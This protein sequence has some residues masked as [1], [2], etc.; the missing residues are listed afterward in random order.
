MLIELAS[1]FGPIVG[2]ILVH[3]V[4]NVES[5]VTQQATVGVTDRLRRGLRGQR[6]HDLERALCAAVQRAATTLAG[7]AAWT[8]VDRT[9][10][11]HL[12]GD[13][14]DLF[15]AGQPGF[16][17]AVL[18]AILF[19]PEAMLQAQLWGAIHPWLANRTPVF[20]DRDTLQRDLPP[21]LVA[22]FGE[23]LKDRQHERAWIAFERELLR[24]THRLLRQQ[25]ATVPESQR[26][27][28]GALLTRLDALAEDTALLGQIVPV[29][30]DAL[31]GI[32]R[33]EAD[34]RDL[35]ALLGEA[36]ARQEER[37]ERLERALNRRLLT[38]VYAG[39]AVAARVEEII[40]EYTEFF[41]S[42]D[43]DLT[44][45]DA[46]VADND[47]GTLAVTGP[48]GFGKS[49]LLANWIARRRGNGLDTACHVFSRR[50]DETRPVTSG[51]RNLLRQLCVYHELR[52]ESIPTDEAGL[53]DAIVGLL[54]ERGAR[55]DEPLVI[56]VD[57]LDEAEAPFTPPLPAALPAGVFV[58]VSVRAGDDEEP[59]HLRGWP[60]NRQRLRLDRLPAAA[61]AV[62]LRR[63]GAGELAALADDPAFV[64]RIGERTDGFALYLR[65]LIGDL[66]ETVRAGGDLIAAVNR[67]PPRLSAY[68]SDRLTELA[69]TN[70]L[71]PPV[72]ELFAL[73]AVADGPLPAEDVR[74]LTG[75]T[76]FGLLG[77][78]WQVTRWFTIAEG[79]RS[80]AFAHPLLGDEFE[81]ALGAQA[82][83]ALDKL[84]GYC[85]DW[86]RHRSRYAFRHLPGHLREADRFE[87]LFA[88]ARDEAFLQA[89]VAAFPS[90]PAL[91]IE[92]LRSALDCAVQLGEPTASAAAE[93]L[94][95]HMRHLKEM[96]SASPLAA[97][98][99]G[100]VD[101]AWQLAELFL[102]ERRILWHLLLAWELS[103]TG[104]LE[105]SRQILNHLYREG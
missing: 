75:L 35:R 60:Q 100:D 57:G 72:E 69:R 52:D 41:V 85:A 22:A 91:P 8:D 86:P 56:V 42:R 14:K 47:R 58:I 31:T 29:T 49:A 38:D 19:E 63:A 93:L 74:A 1:A 18:E 43:D 10:L 101:R 76:V 105:E 102:P 104:K 26:I 7:R 50:T 39:A 6:N 71:S 87:E 59:I 96:T 80:Y 98:R 81:H 92:T 88:L 27:E 25:L 15:P 21:A 83:Q 55:A 73:L 70:V 28:W 30:A 62:W 78:P 51:F 24:E 99:A 45:L 46:F 4:Q 90:E 79:G 9:H 32:E 23:V 12:A 20:R 65:Y 77:L 33:I 68:V 13:A 82:R 95:G 17:G 61:I 44:R 40:A 48:A 34:G 53:R 64:A 89:Q 5:A 103:D 3:V 36:A 16:P 67:T 97:A 94:F 66:V 37:F 84:I 54:R 2:P 11:H